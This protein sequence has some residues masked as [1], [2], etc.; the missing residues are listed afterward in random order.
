M[1]V[2]VRKPKDLLAGLFFATI[3]AFILYVSRNYSFGTAQRM[4]PGYFPS[5]LSGL[6]IMLSVPLLIRSF[7]GKA[8][9]IDKLALRP[10]VLI[11]L[12][13]LLFGLLIRPAG[14]ALSIVAMVIVG[15]AGSSEFKLMPSLA[16][17]VILALGSVLVFVYLLGQ[18]IPVLGYW[19]R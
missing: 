6:L 18:P 3:G 2:F 11:L 13:S 4:G 12:G 10:T 9:T 7:L 14:L 19:F 16:V 17:A 15:A 5:V 8:E 1:S